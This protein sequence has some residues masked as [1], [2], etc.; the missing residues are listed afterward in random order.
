M[1]YPLELARIGFDRMPD[2]GKV[3]RRSPEYDFA[4][5]HPV[6]TAVKRIAKSAMKVVEPARITS[7]AGTLPKTAGCC[8]RSDRCADRNRGKG[9]VVAREQLV[10]H[11]VEIRLVIPLGDPAE[12]VPRRCDQ[13]P[14]GT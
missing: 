7:S 12:P 8:S 13:R 9:T 4:M 1:L 11:I 5:K 14:W 3:L 10:V 2:P 6:E